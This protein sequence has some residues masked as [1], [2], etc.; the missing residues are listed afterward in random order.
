M[1]LV[2]QQFQPPQ[3]R[4]RPAP[5]P[6]PP[7]TLGEIPYGYRPGRGL[8]LS[9]LGHQLALLAIVL[10]GRYAF[11]QP[12]IAITPQFEPSR[13]SEILVLPTLGGGTE[14]NGQRGGGAGDA[15]SRVSTGLRAQS[16]RGFAYPGPQPIISNPPQATLG[17]QT[18]L[19]PSLKNLPRLHRYVPLPNIVQPPPAAS[20]VAT[21][22]PAMVVK[23]GILSFRHPAENAVAVP[24]ITLPVAADSKVANLV[25]A[26][27]A[28][29]Q[30]A[31]PAPVEASDV[32]GVQRDQK[33]LLVLN[34][35]PPPPD[36]G[37][38]IPQAEARSLF[39][40]SPG[41]ATVIADPGAGTKSG[42]QTAMPAG[43][44]SPT[45]IARGDAVAEMA[46][47]GEGGGQKSSGSGAGSGGHYGNA[48]GRGL[49][50]EIG[51]GGGGR[52]TGSGP[53]LG[54]GSATGAGSGAG[55][56]SA[57]GSGG[58]PGITIQGGRYGNSNV[59]NV[60]A[61]VQSRRQ[62]SYN[63]TIVST[64]NSGGGLPD[65]G[66]FHN[67][68]VYTVYLDM[69]STDQDPAPSW[70]LQYAVLQPVP[71]HPGDPVRRIQGTPTPPY[72]MLKEVP[73]FAPELLKG[74]GRQVII[75]SAILD[76]SGKLEQVSVKQSPQD[77]LIAPLVEALQHWIFEPAQIDGQPVAL[78]I[79]L[80]IRLAIPH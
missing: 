50:S 40:V 2:L 32:H 38:R 28:L 7:P 3:A 75:A 29:P 13:A 8:G 49:N 66:V 27:P 44:G 35:V 78:K 42:G 4:L 47:G 19:Q 12:Q 67:E 53:G 24:K 15:A 30:K 79:L 56:G 5:R 36:V 21:K 43:S 68:K 76:T 65:L 61:K 22:E 69:R 14:G 16:R 11:L 37:G 64:S 6:I 52:G 34:A 51:S 39:A 71:H 41:D 54:T 33:G 1:T 70:T 80:G 9:I 73:E 55:A 63:M 77:G 60:E 59:A 58:F 10:F 20:E 18:I 23:T 31:V 46:A 26:K 45:D 72:A 62:T 25:E 57:P 17:I 48:Q 74:N